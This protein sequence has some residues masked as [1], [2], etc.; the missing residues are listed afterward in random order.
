MSALFY[1]R[2]LSDIFEYRNVVI[3]SRGNRSRTDELNFE[4]EFDFGKWGRWVNRFSANLK[5][6][7]M[8]HVAMK[9]QSYTGDLLEQIGAIEE[10]QQWARGPMTQPFSKVLMQ[11]KPMF[12]H[13]AFSKGVVTTKIFGEG[14]HDFEIR[15]DTTRT[16]QST[17]LFQDKLESLRT[18]LADHICCIEALSLEQSVQGVQA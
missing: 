16:T 6:D 15:H 17:R 12:F 2:E 13:A 4:L 11:D 9:L 5:N 14:L 1:T 10:L 8:W 3:M 7:R 18:A